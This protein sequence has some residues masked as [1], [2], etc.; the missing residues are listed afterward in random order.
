MTIFESLQSL[1]EKLQTYSFRGQSIPKYMHQGIVNY[2][3]HKVIPGDFLLSVLQNDLKNAVGYADDEN[4]HL[5]PVYVAFFYFNIPSVAWGSKE[6]VE[7]WIGGE[8]DI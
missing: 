5:L 7:K 4:I 8:Y 3:N 2:V 1:D 6:A